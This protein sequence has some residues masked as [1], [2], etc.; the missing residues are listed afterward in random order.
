MLTVLEEAEFIE[1]FAKED[2]QEK[3]SK[4]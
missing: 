3:S 2:A 4:Q 1:R